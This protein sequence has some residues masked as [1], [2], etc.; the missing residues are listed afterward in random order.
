MEEGE[1]QRQEKEQ[2][3]QRRIQRV[4]EEEMT[5]AVFDHQGVLEEVLE[6]VAWLKEA[7]VEEKNQEI[8]QTKVISHGE[9]RKNAADWIPAIKA[10]L[11]SLFEIKGGLKVVKGEE[12]KKLLREDMAELI[13]SKFVFTIK[14][15]PGHSTAQG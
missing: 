13:P 8:L 1:N 14:P 6:G 11:E 5:N 15:L 2:K 7:I 3:E 12:G 9:V 4:I 10:E